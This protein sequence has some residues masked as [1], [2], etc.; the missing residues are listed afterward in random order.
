MRGYETIVAENT[1][2]LYPEMVGKSPGMVIRLS[3]LDVPEQE[4]V[5]K[6]IPDALYQGKSLIE[7]A[8]EKIHSYDT[9]YIAMRDVAAKFPD[10]SNDVLNW[11]YSEVY[12]LDA[13]TPKLAVVSL[14]KEYYTGGAHGMKQKDY[15]VFDLEEKR[16]LALKDVIRGETFD[17]LDDHV[18][19]AL[20]TLMEIPDWIPLTERGFFDNSIEKME[21]FFL[22]PQ[23]LGFQWDPYEIAPYVMGTLEVVIPYKDIEE[24]FTPRGLVL[25]AELRR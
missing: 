8:D 22:N 16:Q 15:F 4:S 1:L 17:Q 19:A 13:G 2:S 23:G 5:N 9:K 14:D 24:L 10:M 12:T 3:M 20:R 21:D 25:V 18:E 11:H 6:F 7:Y